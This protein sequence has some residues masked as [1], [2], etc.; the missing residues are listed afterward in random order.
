MKPRA[1]FVVDREERVHAVHILRGFREPVS[2]RSS[3]CALGIEHFSLA[4]NFQEK[5][6]AHSQT[7]CPF[8][9]RDDE[10]LKR[11]VV[12]WRVT[13]ATHGD[14]TLEWRFG[15]VFDDKQ[16]NVAITRR[17]TVG[18]RAEENDLLWLVFFFESRDH[19]VNR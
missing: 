1:F 5:R 12:V 11:N 7:F 15:S 19:V 2:W 9:W 10:R 18:V 3:S 13:N 8:C 14:P 17:L 6:I 16:V 4:L